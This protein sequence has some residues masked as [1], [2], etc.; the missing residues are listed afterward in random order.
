VALLVFATVANFLPYYPYLQDF[1]S[2]G[3]LHPEWGVCAPGTDPILWTPSS[4]QV[5]RSSDETA[6]NCPLQIINYP[7]QFHKSKMGKRNFLIQLVM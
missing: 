7:V 1:W 4:P 6:D 2:T 3:L 5:D